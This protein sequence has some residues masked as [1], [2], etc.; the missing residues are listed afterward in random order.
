MDELLKGIRDEVRGVGARLD[1][2]NTRLDE[3][4]TRLDRLERRQTEAEVRVSTQLV[5]VVGAVNEVRDA[6][7]EELGLRRR[8]DDHE[9]RLLAIE[10]RSGERR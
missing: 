10:A 3:T 7:R 4:I 2:T 8:V 6:L 1:E 9:Q 5:A